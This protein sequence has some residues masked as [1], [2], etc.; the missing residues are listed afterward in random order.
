V[1]PRKRT[2]PKPAPAITE[3][4]IAIL[5]GLRHQQRLAV[6]GVP[7]NAPT[8]TDALP[9]H[10]ATGDEQHEVARIVESFK[11]AGRQW[12]HTGHLSF[13]ALAPTYA[14]VVDNADGTQSFKASFIGIGATNGGYST[15][16]AERY[17]RETGLEHA[18]TRERTPIELLIARKQWVTHAHAIRV[19]RTD[20]SA[21]E[22]EQ[23]AT[24]RARVESLLG[25]VIEYSSRAEDDTNGSGPDFVE[26][27]LPEWLPADHAEQLRTYA[28]HFVMT[29]HVISGRAL[30][31]DLATRVTFAAELLSEL[32]HLRE[33]CERPATLDDIDAWTLTRA[34]GTRAPSP[35][36][37]LAALAAQ[38]EQHRGDAEFWLMN[39][40]EVLAS[41]A[42]KAR[43]AELT[44]R[45]EKAERALERERKRR[46]DAEAGLP[47]RTVFPGHMI[48]YGHAGADDFARL[49]DMLENGQGEL[50]PHGNA[51]EVIRSQ[52]E[53]QPNTSQL[54]DMTAA[55]VRAL[56]GVFRLFTRGGDDRRTFNADMLPVDAT[57]F[58]KAAAVTSRR[59][60]DRAAVFDG[61][62]SLS[63]RSLLVA[64]KVKDPKD[65]KT[66]VIGERTPLFEVR[67]M[68]TA[69][70]DGRRALT[71]QEADAIARHYLQHMDAD[72]P[73][74]GPL[75]DRF[76]FT[77]PPLM[78][79]ISDR[80]VLRGDVLD[81]LEA[82]SRAVRGAQGGLNPLD[83]RLLIEI[84]QREQTQHRSK[85]GLRVRSFVDRERLL[86]DHYGAE[87]LAKW[88]RSG[89]LRERATE[90]FENA[91]RALVA[92]GLVA[93][94]EPNYRTTAG[95][96]RDVFEL[97][98]GVVVGSEGLAADD[99]AQTAL[100]LRGK[101]TRR[102]R[103][104]KAAS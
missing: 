12:A 96:S 16:L 40:L 71:E 63:R 72:E 49:A 103:A 35:E 20:L 53:L 52:A 7:K 18:P 30:E 60:K 67:P 62:R 74:T 95:E 78:Q 51:L 73:W 88:R 21:A 43:E 42:R 31:R 47:D 98:P 15:A 46:K 41:N 92:G 87:K 37:W 39:G 97:V 19:A 57:V 66:Y 90:P 69:S 76:V 61:L 65:G 84:T 94:W 4:D 27:S 44:A 38:G 23:L 48:R 81:R 102:T 99:P 80:L 2:T 85:D 6:Y 68:W 34:D 64:L 24:V 8:V 9:P 79:R 55:E 82:G 104:K 75:P 13:G 59:S 50:F 3:A 29:N 32:E 77:L 33:L 83:H 45:A 91:A 56:H 54:G 86:E 26:P 28:E 100:P 25:Y 1:S 17:L 11:E 70:D 5:D 14:E 58:Y 22:S 93:H 36:E 10:S 101:K 89:K